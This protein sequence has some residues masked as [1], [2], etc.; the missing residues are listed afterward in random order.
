MSFYPAGIL[1]AGFSLLVLAIAAARIPPW[2]ASGSDVVT[3][4]LPSNICVGHLL[5]QPTTGEPSGRLRWS[6][7]HDYTG[8]TARPP[9]TPS[10]LAIDRVL[11]PADEHTHL[12]KYERASATAARW[13][14]AE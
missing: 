6:S 10:G 14:A 1:L 11:L 3:G 8:G 4:I 12:I 5:G 9:A 2:I 13:K 7:V